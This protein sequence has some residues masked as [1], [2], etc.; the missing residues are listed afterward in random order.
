M[1][2]ALAVYLGCRSA[3]Q[4]SSRQQSFSPSH[5]KSDSYE[6]AWI[7][8]RLSG[9][10]EASSGAL[11]HRL[12]H[13]LSLYRCSGFSNF[14]DQTQYQQCMRAL[15]ARHAED[16]DRESLTRK[17]VVRPVIPALPLRPLKKRTTSDNKAQESAPAKKEIQNGATVHLSSKSCSTPGHD[18]ELHCRE[19]EGDYEQIIDSLKTKLASGVATHPSPSRICAPRQ[20]WE[21]KSERKLPDA[22]NN[23]TSTQD[24]PSHPSSA[25]SNLRSI[26]LGPSQHAQPTLQ[27][28][29]VELPTEASLSCFSSLNISFLNHETDGSTSR[30]S[31][32]YSGSPIVTP[33]TTS[34][35]PTPPGTSL[36]KLG[37]LWHQHNTV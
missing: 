5:E 17:Y 36:L 37:A 26:S 2:L 10:P 29:G 6:E 27:T 20:Q 31:T 18:L 23:D 12:V 32:I 22:S 7:V 21:S 33:R 9:S 8:F 35:D 16:E 24:T 30:S 34:Q 4:R 14:C 25:S 13:I 3:G 11:C 15:M 28:F 19:V 1:R